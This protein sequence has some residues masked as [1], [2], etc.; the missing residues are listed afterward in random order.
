MALKF[1][2]FG[3]SRSGGLQR[4]FGSLDEDT[5]PP[6]LQSPAATVT[7]HPEHDSIVKELS[8][9]IDKQPLAA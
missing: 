8:E 1:L 7:L 3:A 2:S 5:W 4:H 9:H 6:A